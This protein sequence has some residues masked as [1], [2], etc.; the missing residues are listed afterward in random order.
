M[1]IER[2]EVFWQ[3]ALRTLYPNAADDLIE[4]SKTSPGAV[5]DFLELDIDNGIDDP[6]RKRGV[7]R[8]L[9]AM[10]PPAL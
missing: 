3:G 9:S 1:T 7:E 4:K 6:A 2:P 5:I 8:L 10:R